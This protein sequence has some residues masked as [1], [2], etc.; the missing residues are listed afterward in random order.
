[1]ELG[2]AMGGR[3]QQAAKDRVRL[4]SPAAAPWQKREELREI[5]VNQGHQSPQSTVPS[6][7]IWPGPRGVSS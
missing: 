3:D 5:L 7:E 1:M 2:Q 6:T 4:L